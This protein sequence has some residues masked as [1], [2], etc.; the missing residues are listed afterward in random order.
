MEMPIGAGL[1]IQNGAAS[2]PTRPY[3]IK[4]VKIRFARSA[5]NAQQ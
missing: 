2:V 4:T 1:S 3:E 5:G